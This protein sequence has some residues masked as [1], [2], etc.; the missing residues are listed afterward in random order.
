MNH[1]VATPNYF[2]VLGAGMNRGRSLSADDDENGPPVAVINET[3]ARYY[4]GDE[5]PVGSRIRLF[6]S[7]DAPWI[8]VVGV[9]ADFRN[10]GLHRSVWPA[11][12]VPLAQ[13]PARNMNLLL[14][15]DGDPLAMVPAARAAVAEL[16]ADMPLFRI[17]SMQQVF[18]NRFWGETL[19]MKLL[20]WCALGALLLAVVGI[21]GVI[22]YA[23]N[24]R[25]HEMGVRIA[26]GA[27]AGDVV[28]LV[29]RQGMALAAVGMAVGLLLGF[30][31]SRGLSFMLFGVSGNDPVTYASVL[32]VL[33]LV[34]ML[35]SWIPARRAT[36]VDPIVVLRDE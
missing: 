25:T 12:Y 11:V 27:R 30:G 21:Y 6:G 3:S 19:T 33:A 28:R 20:A 26:L 1:V 32:A 24:Q 2:E 10:N 17:M 23:V 9:V 7:D 29:V 8:E 31:L 15:A 35:A 36:R 18:D 4:W 13:A 14:R 34:A 5:D 22:S 16:D